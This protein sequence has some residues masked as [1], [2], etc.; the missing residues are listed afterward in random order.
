MCIYNYIDLDPKT[1]TDNFLSLFKVE[2]VQF[3]NI[4]FEL[5]LSEMVL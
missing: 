5:I 3:S 4:L 1:Y 2:D